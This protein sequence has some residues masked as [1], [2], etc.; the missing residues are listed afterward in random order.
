MSRPYSR[1]VRGRPHVS[2]VTSG[3]VLSLVLAVALGTVQGVAFAGDTGKWGGPIDPDALQILKRMTDYLGGLQQFAMHT[4]NTYEDVLETG[5]KVQFGFSSDVVVQRPNKMRVERT[6]GFTR[7]FFIYDGTT[8]S[9]HD[10]QHDVYAVVASPENLDGLLHFARDS[11]DLVPPA[12]DMIFSNAFQL[13]TANVT[14]GLVVGE[15]VIS[16]VRC[17]HLAFTTPVV[18]WQVWIADG[19]AP[20]PYRYVLT[21]RDDPAQPQFATV[22]SNWSTEPKIDAETFA[23]DPPATA[24]EIDFLKVDAGD[25]S[26]R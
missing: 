25:A 22:I 23:F 9:V 4:E 11:L 2:A 10:D 19:D 14:S 21:T 17:D 24:M 13:L 5:Q 3:A 12:G 20:L 26:A 7:Q 1:F 6:D 18:D 16:G 15:A 8:L